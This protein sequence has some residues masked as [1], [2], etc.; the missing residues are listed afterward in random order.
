MIRYIPLKSHLTDN[1]YDKIIAKILEELSKDN[2]HYY[3][4]SWEISYNDPII[5]FLYN[6]CSILQ[7]LKPQKIGVFAKRRYCKKFIKRAGAHFLYR[8][9][10]P[11]IEKK[12][13][14]IIFYCN[15]IIHE[16]YP[17]EVP[18]I[19]MREIGRKYYMTEEEIVE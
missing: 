12:Y 15:K 19:I 16:L 9:K 17:D 10:R 18:C 2:K 7:L 8:L 5:R 6:I 11:P 3:I 4:H 13:E 1:D 14:D